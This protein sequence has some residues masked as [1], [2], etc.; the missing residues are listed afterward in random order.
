[1]Y[2]GTLAAALRRASSQLPC[3]LDAVLLLKVQPPLLSLVSADLKHL[4]FTLYTPLHTHKD[5]SLTAH[6]FCHT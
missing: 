6:W 1:M 4:I 5:H 3:F 2:P